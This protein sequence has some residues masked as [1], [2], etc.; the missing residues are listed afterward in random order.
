MTSAIDKRIVKKKSI[1]NA[2]GVGVCNYKERSQC[3]VKLEQRSGEGQNSVNETSRVLAVE[4]V[5]SDGQ[6]LHVL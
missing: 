4:V 1:G 6:T 2:T 5:K 3:K